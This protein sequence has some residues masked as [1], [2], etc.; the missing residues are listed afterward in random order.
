MNRIERLK[1]GLDYDLDKKRM[2]MAVKTLPESLLSKSEKRIFHGGCLSCVSQS[3]E[4]VKRC[5]GC[6]FFDADWKKPNLSYTMENRLE[7]VDT[8][9]R[10]TGRNSKIDSILE[11]DE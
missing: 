4:S 10:M 7:R 9:K 5:L 6:Q 3:F 2:R 8:L 1:R 11:T